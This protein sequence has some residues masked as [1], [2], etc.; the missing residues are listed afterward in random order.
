MAKNRIPQEMAGVNVPKAIRRSS[1]CA[2]SR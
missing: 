1:C 2:G